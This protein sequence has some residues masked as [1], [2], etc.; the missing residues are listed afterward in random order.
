LDPITHS[1]TLAAA[2][3]AAAAALSTAAAASSATAS[4]TLVASGRGCCSCSSLEAALL[5]FLEF[6]KSLMFCS[7]RRSSCF[8]FCLMFG[9]GVWRRLL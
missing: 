3:R 4:S 1:R 7:A 5:L 6:S 2:L 9:G 8:V